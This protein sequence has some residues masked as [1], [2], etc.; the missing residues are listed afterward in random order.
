MDKLQ[1]TKEYQIE[2]CV[3]SYEEANKAERRGADQIELCSALDKDGLT[4][5]TTD[6]EK[7]L[8]ELSAPIKV[9]IRPY[10]GSFITQAEHLT[11]MKSE[12]KRMKEIGIERIVLGLTTA[13]GT[14]D[15]AALSDLRDI[16]P[17]MKITVHKA[18]DTCVDPVVEVAAL[19]KAGGFDS[20]LTSG[21]AK[22]ALEGA[23]VIKEMI[24]LA[25]DDI[26]IIS[27]GSI[28]NANLSIIHDLLGGRYY[29][30]RRIVG[31]L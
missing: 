8:T 14:L 28:T 11:M 21:G 27:A 30:G 9:M 3:G 2:A 24:A 19:L 16:A 13:E 1:N 4:P 12:I 29:H 23:S 17:S 5:F 22:T 18:I 15:M 6:I 26:D 25:S 7:C 20:V 31:Q 10:E